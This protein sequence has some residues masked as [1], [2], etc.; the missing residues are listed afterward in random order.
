VRGQIDGQLQMR[1]YLHGEPQVTIAFNPDLFVR[2]REMRGP[3]AS[4]PFDDITFHESVNSASF[5]SS[6][7][8][9]LR[10]P[11][12]QITRTSHQSARSFVPY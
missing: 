7:S 11:H 8:L 9:W 4:M 12:G 5:D 3:T 2:N 1:S 6:R 10:P